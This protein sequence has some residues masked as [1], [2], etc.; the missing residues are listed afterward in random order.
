MIPPP[1]I[2]KVKGLIPLLNIA[3][4]SA[5][6]ELL[7]QTLSEYNTVRIRDCTGHERNIYGLMP[8]LQYELWK[9]PLLISYRRNELPLYKPSLEVR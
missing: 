4:S 5:Q 6:N 2:S 7:Q 3:L 9:S 8:N 1:M